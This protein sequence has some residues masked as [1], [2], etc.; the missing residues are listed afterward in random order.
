MAQ[1]NKAAI[2]Q[3]DDLGRERIDIP[4]WKGHGFVRALTADEREAWEQS[5]L[6]GQANA[7][8]IRVS[9]AIAV[10]CDDQ[11]K[12]MFTQA[13]AKQLRAKSGAAMDR[14]F[15]AGRKLNR[16][17]PA[18]VTELAAH[19]GGAPAGQASPDTA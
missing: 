6:D 8:Q 11:G 9:F 7:E 12:P 16:I 5:I 10:L 4:E 19:S 3:A 15:E 17:R 1:L 2:L 18:D 13:D 14:I